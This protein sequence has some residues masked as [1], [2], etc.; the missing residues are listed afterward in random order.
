MNKKGIGTLLTGAVVGATLGLFFAPRKGSETRKLVSKKIEEFYTELKE[1]DYEEVKVQLEEKINEIKDELNDLD[2]EKVLEIAKEKSELIKVK[3]DELG[4]YA[5][6]KATPV[7]EDTIEELRKAALK[8]TK[9]ITKKLEA[10][11]PKKK[12]SK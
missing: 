3:L 9:E 7:I 12:I 4:E 10:K 2:K 6:D 8:A 1:L 11:E 5:K